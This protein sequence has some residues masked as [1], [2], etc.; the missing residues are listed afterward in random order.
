[1]LSLS[2]LI[3][4]NHVHLQVLGLE[5][6]AINSVQFSN[7]TE[8]GKWKGQILSPEELGD[9]YEGLKMNQIHNYTHLLTGY[10]GSKS[11]LLKVKDIIEEQRLN[12]PKLTYV[13]DPVMGDCGKMYL[14]QE[15]LEVYKNDIIPLADIVTPNQ[16]EAELLTDM[17][18]TDI[19][20]AKQAMMKLHS[21]GPKTVIISSLEF[22]SELDLF[23]CGSTITNGSPTMMQVHIPRLDAQ[24]TGS[25]DLFT[26]LLLAWLH[27]HSDDFQ[28]ACGKA[29]STMQHVLRR[30]LAHSKQA[31][32]HPDTPS[33]GRMELRLIQS[34][35]DI[36]DPQL[37]VDV[38]TLD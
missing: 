6:D 20:S 37:C 17:K 25:G 26:A 30:T 14:P 13:C 33:A 11:F 22:G 19:E 28:L 34:A 4:H 36:K 3:S 18:I 38:Q 21:M 10:I 32:L 12:D 16:F 35:S 1:M 9:L 31:V 23:G 5:I 29:V 8:Y 27:K 7:H 15:L 24:F 2:V